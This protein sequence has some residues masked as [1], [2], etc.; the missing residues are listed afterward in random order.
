MNHSC[1]PNLFHRYNPKINRL[2]IHALRDITPGEELNTSYIDICHPTVIRRQ[3]LKGWGFICLC[4]V[5]ESTDVEKDHSR[6]VLEDL[7]KKVRKRDKQ[8]QA[9]GGNW[10]ERDYEKSLVMI[11]RGMRLMEQQGMAETDTLGYLLPLAAICGFKC[12]Q[13]DKSLAWIERLMQLERRCLGEDSNEYLDAV[14]LS[15]RYQS[16]RLT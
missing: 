13:E 1:A 2:T 5:C 4:P 14:D 7:L 9:S 16:T 3:M 8:Q 12:H 6:K 10:T 15:P 11:E